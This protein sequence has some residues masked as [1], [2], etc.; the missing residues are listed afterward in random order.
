MV[1]GQETQQVN[2][3]TSHATKFE[4]VPTSQY[5]STECRAHMKRPRAS[6]VWNNLSIRTK[7]GIVIAH[8]RIRE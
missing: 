8:Q 2:N 5:K 4:K 6:S 7:I 1:S 3:A